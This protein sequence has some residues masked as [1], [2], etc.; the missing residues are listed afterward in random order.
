MPSIERLD[1]DDSGNTERADANDSAC[2][3]KGELEC[4]SNH[5]E[6]NS[7]H[8]SV[9]VVRSTPS[10][11]SVD[12]SSSHA[13]TRKQSESSIEL[14]P[15][16]HYSPGLEDFNCASD[17]EIHLISTDSENRNKE[18]QLTAAHRPCL[19]D[20]TDSHSII[21]MCNQDRSTKRRRCPQESDDLDKSNQAKIGDTKSCD[22]YSDQE[23]SCILSCRVNKLGIPR[24]RL[25]R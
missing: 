9:D 24:T 7:F 12:S 17:H 1:N 16:L 2:E 11:A 18:W 10:S 5:F 20:Q 8:E 14:D 21:I 3:Y 25:T 19:V 6:P 22:G 23:R 4:L 13:R 15:E